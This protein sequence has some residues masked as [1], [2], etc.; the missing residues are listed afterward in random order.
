M[1]DV[2]KKW[3]IESIQNNNGLTSRIFD[4]DN[5]AIDIVKAGLEPSNFIQSILNGILVLFHEIPLPEEVSKIDP[6][7]WV[8]EYCRELGNQRYNIPDI[9]NGDHIPIAFQGEAPIPL[10]NHIDM[11]WE[12]FQLIAFLSRE[13]L[14]TPIDK[15]DDLALNPKV[16]EALKALTDCEDPVEQIKKVCLQSKPAHI[17][18]NMLIAYFSFII[19]PITNVCFGEIGGATSIIMNVMNSRMSHSNSDDF[20]KKKLGSRYQAELLLSFVSKQLVALEDVNKKIRLKP[21][22]QHFWKEIAKLP[23]GISPEAENFF[24]RLF[25]TF[26]TELKLNEF[27]VKEVIQQFSE[28]DNESEKS[29]ISSESVVEDSS[30]SVYSGQTVETLSFEST[31][32][33]PELSAQ[34]YDA[35]KAQ[36]AL[37]NKNYIISV[38]VEELKLEGLIEALVDASKKVRVKKLSRSYFA[39]LASLKIVIDEE[40]AKIKPHL[41]KMLTNIANGIEEEIK[42]LPKENEFKKSLNKLRVKSTEPRMNNVIK[43]IAEDG[44]K[45][46]PN[47]SQRKV[48]EELVNKLL[49]M[50]TGFYARE[51]YT[52]ASN[53]SFLRAFSKEI[54]DR[55]EILDIPEEKWKP[56]LKSVLLSFTVVGFFIVVGRAIYAAANPDKHL[57]PYIFNSS[58]WNQAKNARQTAKELLPPSKKLRT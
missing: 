35:I 2:R 16:L 23:K 4:A 1:R 13:L 46:K 5:G 25:S 43:D 56:V 57:S 55:Q 52:E 26:S 38:C 18:N 40:G 54:D 17:F 28:I 48:S 9:L 45:F 27:L 3:D 19:T 34:K 50:T 21:W 53:Q 42:N 37:K 58:L 29:E 15:T 31:E 36:L 32:F 20:L 8:A 41:Q 49:V 10:R 12:S 30:E 14:F 39:L 47:S 6:P 51:S 24:D 44:Q 11:I 22:V 33:K 7:A